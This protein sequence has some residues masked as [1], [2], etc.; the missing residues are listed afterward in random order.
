MEDLEKSQEKLGKALELAK[1]GED[2]DLAGRVRDMGERLVRILYGLIKM[3]EIHDIENSAFMKPSEEFEAVCS[4]LMDL[5]GAVHIVTVEDQVFVNDIRIRLG[6]AQNAASLGSELATHQIGGLSFHQAPSPEQFKLL[7]QLLSNDPLSEDTPRAA[8]IE[9]LGAEGMD[10]ID[11][12]GIYRFRVSG[13]NSAPTLSQERVSARAASLIEES[14]DNLAADRLPNPLPLRRAVTD[15]LEASKDDPDAFIDQAVSANEFGYHTL[16]VCRLSLLIAKEAKL[17][18][19]AIQDLGV[20]AMFHDMGYAAREGADP[21][22]GEPGYPPPYERHASAGARML[23]R[24]RGFHQ[25]KIRRALSTLEHH[26]DY[27]HKGGRPSI[28]ARIIRLAEDFANLTRSG[29]GGLNPHEALVRMSAYGG[30]YYDY[31][32]LQAFI[33]RLGKYPPGTLLEVE[34]ELKGNKMTFVLLSQSLVRSPETFDK[35]ICR[36]VRLHDGREPPAAMAKRP[37]DLA[38]KGRVIRVLNDY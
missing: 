38:N 6:R 34:M 20:C 1:M 10:F 11:L 24:Q 9:R 33:N 17:S 14:W 8:M 2:L 19:E 3:T 5:L 26:R 30:K 13:D 16:K 37:I 28:F 4:E 23:L 12:F 22:I 18:E 35:P 29:G 32:L 31:I 27:N 36:L 7:I 25:A 21:A 15:I